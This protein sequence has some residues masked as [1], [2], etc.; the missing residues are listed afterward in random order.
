MKRRSIPS[1]LKVSF[2]VQ[3]ILAIGLGC[4]KQKPESGKLQNEPNKVVHLAIW[5]Y[6]LSS[7]TLE[8]FEKEKGIKVHVTHYSS[9]EELLAKL[10]TGAS[11][12]DVVLPAD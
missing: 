3:L 6:Y 4:Y 10:Q 12:Y 2:F 5:P 9:N 11:L 8:Q 7:E 1:Y